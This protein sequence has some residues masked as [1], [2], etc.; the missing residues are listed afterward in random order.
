MRVDDEIQAGENALLEIQEG[1]F[2][3]L[4]E[5]R[6]ASAFLSRRL[7]AYTARK[8]TR[9]RY[10]VDKIEFDK[11]VKLVKYYLSRSQFDVQIFSDLSFV[12]NNGRGDVA[13]GKCDVVAP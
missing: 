2:S 7:F 10:E 1:Q 3:V 4:V 9:D 8:V 13:F 12:E 5:A 11:N 6:G